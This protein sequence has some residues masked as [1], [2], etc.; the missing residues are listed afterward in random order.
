MF[1][2]VISACCLVVITSLNSDARPY[3]MQHASECNVTMPC[4]FS[5]YAQIPNQRREAREPIADTPNQTTLRRRQ[6]KY[7]G[8]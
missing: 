1:K 7:C 2:Q 6:Y 5:N 4:D 8:V 3:R